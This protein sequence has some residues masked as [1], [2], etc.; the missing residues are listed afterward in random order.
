MLKPI[1]T[2][3]LLSSAVVGL[4][5]HAATATKTYTCPSASNLY[6]NYAKGTTFKDGLSQQTW[7]HSQSIM[8]KGLAFSAAHTNPYGA[9]TG[10]VTCIYTGGNLG[11]TYSITSPVSVRISAQG[12]ICLPGMTSRTQCTFTAA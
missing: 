8:N 12:G 11:Q 2:S 9:P 3:L 1:L 4:T 7:R 6:A 5:V 10:L